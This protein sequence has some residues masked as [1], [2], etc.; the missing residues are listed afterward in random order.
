MGTFGIDF[1]MG[2]LKGGSLDDLDSCRTSFDTISMTGET[3]M[4]RLF[5]FSIFT[6][7]DLTRPL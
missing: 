4:R 1:D 3:L 7:F 2:P 5:E 6:F